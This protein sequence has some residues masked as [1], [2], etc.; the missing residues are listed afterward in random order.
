MRSIGV[1]ALALLLSP[2]ALSQGADPAQQPQP[3]AAQPQQPPSYAN[4]SI[5]LVNPAGGA[6]VLMHN[7]KNELEYVDVAKTKDAFAA[8][9]VPAR[10]AEISELITLLDNEVIR[11][12]AE[13]ARLQNAQQRTVIVAPAAPPQPSAAE[14]QAEQQAQRRQQLLQAWMVLQANRP[15]PYQLPMPVNPNAN[16]LRTNCTTTTMG[17]VTTTNCN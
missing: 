8:G 13:N 2:F 1:I 10:V 9:Y 16:R 15:Q 3:A 6:V 12:R 17:G 4:Y 14:I 7:P 5:M 11:L